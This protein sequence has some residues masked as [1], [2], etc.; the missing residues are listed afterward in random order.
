MGQGGV[1]GQPNRPSTSGD[2]GTWQNWN[3]SSGLVTQTSLDGGTGH[4]SGVW[5][6]NSVA[7]NVSR[8]NWPIPVDSMK[9]LYTGSTLT[10][11]QTASL[12]LRNLP[13]D[14]SHLYMIIDCVG[15]I[16]GTGHTTA[17]FGFHPLGLQAF[18]STTGTGGVLGGYC[19]MGYVYWE[20]NG[21]SNVYYQGSTP[22]IGGTHPI[23]IISPLDYASEFGNQAYSPVGLTS[24]TEMWLLNYSRPDVSSKWAKPAIFSTSFGIDAYS[25][26]A[27]SDNR[28]VYH[29]YTYGTLDDN[30]INSI[31]FRTHDMNGTV[32][33]NEPLSAR[34]QVFGVQ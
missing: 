1:I 21:S 2:V 34:V 33:G 4:A 6:L 16:A 27:Y 29:S 31:T 9:Y 10:S 28:P 26:W 20:Y 5:D 24:H 12:R 8:N 13:Q 22:T 7:Q 14:Y 30:N 25:V 19:E 32:T 11:S 23:G 15:D 18:Q 3:P 17:N